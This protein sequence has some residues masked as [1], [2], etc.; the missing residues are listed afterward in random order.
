LWPPAVFSPVLFVPRRPVQDHG[1]LG[2]ADPPGPGPD[3]YHLGPTLRV[4]HV[5]EGA[6]QAGGHLAQPALAALVQGGALAVGADDEP[7]PGSVPAAVMADR[8]GFAVDDVDRR[9]A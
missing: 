1:G 6:G 4:E 3:R 9:V 7:V 2:D 5:G 8:V